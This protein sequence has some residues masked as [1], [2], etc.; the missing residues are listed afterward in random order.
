MSIPSIVAIKKAGKWSVEFIGDDA[1]QAKQ[2]AA[3]VNDGKIEA[4]RGLL[5]IRPEPTKKLSAEKRRVPVPPAEAPAAKADEAAKAEAPAA[6]VER[7]G[8]VA[9]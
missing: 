2:I 3:K 8:K 4:E 1:D 9:A 5:F 7:K 6:K